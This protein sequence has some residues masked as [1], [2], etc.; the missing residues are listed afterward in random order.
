MTLPDYVCYDEKRCAEFLPATVYPNNLTC[1]R[2]HELGLKDTET[3]YNIET[4]VKYVK[5]RFRA[6]LVVTNGIHYC[7]YS[8]MYQCQNSS[9]CISKQRLLDGIE[10]CPFND[11]ETFNQSCSL[12]DIHQRFNCSDDDGEKCFSWIVVQDQ[13]SKV[14]CKYGE[15]E[16]DEN[17]QQIQ[18]H[19][20]FRLI[21][22]GK[23]H[24]SPIIIDGHN[25]TDESD[26]VR[27]S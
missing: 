18:T 22:D 19:I 3:Y 10:D 6:C 21:C 13:D 25:E 15:D 27:H 24:M 2:F 20:Y 23:T 17:D 4:L 16:G 26:F 14:N 12:P 11:N 8:T 9:K 5:S 7:N 1:R